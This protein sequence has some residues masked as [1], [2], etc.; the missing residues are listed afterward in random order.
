MEFNTMSDFLKLLEETLEATDNLL[1]EETV[2][3]VIEEYGFT[4]EEI[5]EILESAELDDEEY[6]AVVEALQ[7]SVK[8]TGD[9]RRRASRKV[10]QRRASLTTGMSKLARKLRARKAAKTKRK[11]PAI[12]RKANRR[13]RKAMR[14]RK[15]RGIK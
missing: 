6:D 3:N 1:F 2:Y 14:I 4:D 9:T 12:K 7:K 11:N 10:R 5:L 13:R 8:Y 15:Q